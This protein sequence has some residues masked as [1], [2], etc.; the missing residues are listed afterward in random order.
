MMPLSARTTAG[1]REESLWLIDRL[2]GDFP[3]FDFLASKRGD[4]RSVRLAPRLGPALLLTVHPR[5]FGFLMTVAEERSGLFVQR[6]AIRADSYIQ[7]SRYLA[8]F[9]DCLP[10]P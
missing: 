1:L 10:Y 7:L 5:N 2:R 3:T 4:I 8:N 9:S 6:N